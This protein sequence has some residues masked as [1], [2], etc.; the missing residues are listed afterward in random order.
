MTQ[1]DGDNL[2]PTGLTREE[3]LRIMRLLSG[4]ESVTMAKAPI[5]NYL[6][7]ELNDL[8]EVLEREILGGANATQ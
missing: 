3:M 2:S 8:V 1:S 7:E 4:M 5:P 6:I